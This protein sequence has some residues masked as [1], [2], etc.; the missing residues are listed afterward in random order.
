M[1]KPTRVKPIL[2][3]LL[4][5]IMTNK[6]DIITLHDVVPHSI[7]DHDLIMITVKISKSKRIPVT[8][9]FCH[10]TNYSCDAVCF[11]LIQYNDKLQQ[12]LFNDDINKQVDILTN[13]FTDCRD[14]SAPLVTKKVTRPHIPWFKD[15]RQGVL[16][17]RNSIQ[18]QLTANIYNI[19]LQQQYKVEQNFVKALSKAEYYHN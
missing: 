5:D 16:M 18:T 8:K 3:T 15:E 14:T 10:F 7:A 13:T 12:T 1:N 19:E 4:D 9:T 11:L 17:N 6:L 2:A